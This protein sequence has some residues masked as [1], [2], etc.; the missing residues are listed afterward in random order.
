MTRGGG[1]P[2]DII[3]V[4]SCNILTFPVGAVVKLAAVIVE[5]P[6]ADA[7]VVLATEMVEPPLAGKV[8]VLVGAVSV[9]WDAAR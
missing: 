8:R 3:A 5:A 4:E 2:A 1:H 9:V 6:L 7:M